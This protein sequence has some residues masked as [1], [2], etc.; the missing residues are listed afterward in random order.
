[1]IKALTRPAR[2]F[3]AVV[4]LGA[5]AG[6]GAGPP[7]QAADEQ[8]CIKAAECRGFLPQICERCGDGKEACAHWTCVHRKCTMQI[9]PR[10]RR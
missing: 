2:F 8:S 10:E 1:M 9:C 3:A 4:V 6:V 7:A 5:L